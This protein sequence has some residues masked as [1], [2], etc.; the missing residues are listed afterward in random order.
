MYGVRPHGAKPTH[1]GVAVETNFYKVMSKLN[2]PPAAHPPL[3]VA[4]DAGVAVG[5]LPRSHWMPRE[6]SNV[7]PRPTTFLTSP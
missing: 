7:N 4:M 1:N 6:L 2:R 5:W 3:E